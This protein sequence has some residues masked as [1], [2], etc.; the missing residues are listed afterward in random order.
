MSPSSIL[1]WP[2]CRGRVAISRIPGRVIMRSKHVGVQ[3]SKQMWVD[4]RLACPTCAMCALSYFL[5]LVFAAL[6]MICVWPKL[7]HMPRGCT[8]FRPRALHTAPIGLPIAR[9]PPWCTRM[10]FC[11]MLCLALYCEKCLT[12]I[13][14]SNPASCCGGVSSNR[15]IL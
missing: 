3:L 5:P 10:P 13:T 14:L 1:Q 2:S 8:A 15:S 7:L 9:M 12:G 4:A 6:H 11:I